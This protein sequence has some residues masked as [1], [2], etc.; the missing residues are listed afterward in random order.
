MT[1]IHFKAFKFI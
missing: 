1:I